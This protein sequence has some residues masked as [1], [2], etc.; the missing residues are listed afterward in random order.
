MWRLLWIELSYQRNRLILFCG[1]WVTLSYFIGKSLDPA[2][3]WQSISS[4]L[5]ILSVTLSYQLANFIYDVDA[6][7]NRL[8]LWRL[9]PLEPWEL[10]AFRQMPLLIFQSIVTILCVFFFTLSEEITAVLIINLNLAILIYC[11]STNAIGEWFGTNMRWAATFLPLLGYLI[12][13]ISLPEKVDHVSQRFLE[14]FHCFWFLCLEAIV[15]TLLLVL[16]I[17]QGKKRFLENA[18]R[19]GK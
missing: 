2:L 16:L 18:M 15:C 17:T 6:K 7:E 3:R 5:A 1:V 14:Y 8:N 10:A 13:G 19:S 9:L 12:L 11:F 4:I